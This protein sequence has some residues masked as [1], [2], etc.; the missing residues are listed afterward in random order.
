M[1]HHEIL[2]SEIM[3]HLKDEYYSLKNEHENIISKIKSTEKY[4][5][6]SC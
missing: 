3:N 4:Q 5:V 2:Y 1:F 6:Q